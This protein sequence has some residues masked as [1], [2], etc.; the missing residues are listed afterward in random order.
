MTT[1][2][3][4][5]GH[6]EWNDIQNRL[7]FVSHDRSPDVSDKNKRYKAYNN[8]HMQTVGK[9]RLTPN[10][11]G[12]LD[13]RTQV[14]QARKGSP[15]LIG[16]STLKAKVTLDDIKAVALNF[17]SN[18]EE[19]KVSISFRQLVSTMQFN[20]LLKALLQYFYYFFDELEQDLKA[21][22]T[23]YLEPSKA[24]RKALAEVRKQMVIA[25]RQLG[26]SYCALLLGL[27]GLD[28]QH[29]MGC[30]KQR[31]S[32]T[33]RD[34]QMFEN[35]YAFCTFVVWIA[36]RRRD[37][38]RIQS[39]VGNML[40]SPAFNPATRP[41]FGDMA[42]TLNIPEKKNVKEHTDLSIHR[43]IEELLSMPLPVIEKLTPAQ[44]RR[45][46]GKRTAIMEAIHQ[47]ST[48]LVS[49]LPL[50]REQAIYLFSPLPHP[51]QHK[52]AIPDDIF[53]D[54]SLLYPVTIVPDEMLGIIGE[55]RDLFDE[56]LL[57]INFGGD[58]DTGPRDSESSD[59][60]GN[61]NLKKE[62]NGLQRTILSR[63][64]TEDGT[65]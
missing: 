5:K 50:P 46:F 28:K 56:E 51:R 65:Y 6:F 30:G 52:P 8:Y 55:P 20:N 37:F 13:F 17:L 57:P 32:S 43:R 15:R 36:F 2:P 21:N 38:D 3:L 14:L 44:H 19:E 7:E 60:A 61:K 33:H 42:Q 12:N 62:G 54:K 41:K 49:L 40:R 35:L 31:V 34:K 11:S 22:K 39:E 10:K 45:K 59:L 53:T 9:D 23:S 47:R 25:K 63:A 26:R 64:T 4:R 18:K 29:H 48:A 16:R 58:D 1:F 24:E 27:G